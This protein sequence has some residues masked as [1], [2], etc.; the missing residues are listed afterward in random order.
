MSFECAGKGEKRIE[1][2]GAF[3]FDQ[4]FV[5]SSQV[6]KQMRV[7]QM[8]ARVIRVK[9]ECAFELFFGAAPPDDGEDELRAKLLS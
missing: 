3:G 7:K 8:C 1:F 5:V 9:I 6:G 2:A 4:G